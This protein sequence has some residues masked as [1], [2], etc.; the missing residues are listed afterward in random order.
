MGGLVYGAFLLGAHAISGA[1]AEFDIGD[2]E[3]ALLAVTTLGGG[4][5]CAGMASV[6]RR[7]GG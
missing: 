1:E 5:I 7:S 6:R 2:P 4:L 3:I